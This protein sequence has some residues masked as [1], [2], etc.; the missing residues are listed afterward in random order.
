MLC[1]LSDILPLLAI[2]LLSIDLNHFF[3][4]PLSCA[5]FV[6]ICCITLYFCLAGILN[7]LLYAGVL[8]YIFVML[9]AI[10]AFAKVVLGK[11]W[12]NF[13]K[14]INNCGFLLFIVL[15]LFTL[16]YFYYRKPLFAEWDELSFWGTASKL[17]K[18]NNALYTKATIGWNWVPSQCPGLVVLGY[19]V[20]FLGEVFCEWKVFWAY[21]L[22]LFSIISMFMG[23]DRSLNYYKN[24]A[25][26]VIAILTPYIFTI[27]FRQIYVCPLYMSSY[28]DIPA[29]FLFAGCFIL[30]KKTI[31]MG[32]FWPTFIAIM[33]F[34]SVKDNTFVLV[35]LIAVVIIIHNAVFSF[36]SVRNDY[37]TQSLVAL[38]EPFFL[39]LVACLPYTIWKYY[40]NDIVAQQVVSN[41]PASTTAST[42]N[43]V[44]NGLGM[45]LNLITPS[46]RFLE[47]K[48]NFINAYF[49]DNISFLGSGVIVTALILVIS[50]IT[51]VFQQDRYKRKASL[52][53]TVLL[54]LGL[55]GYLFVL[56]LS[57]AF[58]FKENEA[59]HLA[60][61]NRYVTTYYIG[62]FLIALSEITSVAMQ[63]TSSILVSGISIFSLLLLFKLHTLLPTYCTALA[64]PDSYFSEASECKSKAKYIQQKIEPNSRVFFVCQ[65]GNGEKWFRYSYELLPAIL[66]YSVS[67]GGSYFLPEDY[68]GQL[69]QTSLSKNEMRQYIKT[70]CD[71][72]FIENVDNYFIDN[73]GDL[74]SDGLL[75]CDKDT[76]VLYKVTT[77]QEKFLYISHVK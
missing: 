22:L 31:H 15:S 8:F 2:A 42:T 53:T 41:L 6:S 57:Y 12:R 20:Q 72:V 24:F 62:W 25:S 39:L 18:I 36:N 44:L 10:F 27:Y 34:S 65:G 61:Y 60:S 29:G 11:R 23:D 73:Y 19:W 66:D 1:L 38:S 13:T 45:L 37:R 5:P 49:C 58:I 14:S 69:Y 30:Y 3:S 21:D 7:V 63:D 9:S 33:F 67:G 32:K 26:S 59:A 43:I 17:M 35:L 70:N 64:Y 50:V 40:I 76:S 28:A 48:A 46:T 47:T 4:L 68:T 56:F 51:V 55:L 71:Y 75:S 77:N 74:F 52:L 16:I 54:T